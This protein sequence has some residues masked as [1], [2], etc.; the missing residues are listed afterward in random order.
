MLHQ[1]SVKIVHYFRSQN[2]VDQENVDWCVYLTEVR[3]RSFLNIVIMCILGSIFFSIQNVVA[4]IVV[5]KLVR[6][7]VGGFHCKNPVVCFFLS[8]SVV[9]V[10]LFITDLLMDKPSLFIAILIVSMV[11]IG[12]KPPQEIDSSIMAKKTIV[13]Q[14]RVREL[15]I[16]TLLCPFALLG[17]SPAVA[18]IVGYTIAATFSAIVIAKH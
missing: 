2:Y 4:L 7:H 12:R 1:L 5:L 13:Q 17:V 11:V 6:S 8:M 9:M 18:G 16:G 15:A 3:L 10:G 14:M